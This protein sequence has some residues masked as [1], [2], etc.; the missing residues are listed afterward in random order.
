MCRLNFD[1]VPRT[2]VSEAER[3]CF[4][5][6]SA[7]LPLLLCVIISGARRP[8]ATLRRVAGAARLPTHVHGKR[9]N[10]SIIRSRAFEDQRVRLINCDVKNSFVASP[11]LFTDYYA[12]QKGQPGGIR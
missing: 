4:E 5:K 10:P 11:S 3:E 7:G 1:G 9:P 6:A 2:T 8:A 12:E